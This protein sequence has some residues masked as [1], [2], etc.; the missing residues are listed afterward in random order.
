MDRQVLL[1]GRQHARHELTAQ[2]V[3]A[4]ATGRRDRQACFSFSVRAGRDH[5]TQR[6]KADAKNDEG[7]QL[8][9][10]PLGA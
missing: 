1:D 5:V 10:A 4:C 7:L 3:Q 2:E 8:A 9:L 6:W